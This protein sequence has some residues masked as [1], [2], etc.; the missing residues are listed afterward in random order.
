M[1]KL[2]ILIAFWC[3]SVNAQKNIPIIKNS[4]IQK[5]YQ[6]EELEVLNK[7]ILKN[8]YFERISSLSNIIPY[9]ALTAK[10]NI[11]YIDIGIPNTKENEKLFT[12]QKLLITEYLKETL[13]F[14]ENI[15]AYSSK[16]DLIKSILFYEDVLKNI[17]ILKED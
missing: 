16:D 5:Y 15:I 8:L 11:S 9:L 17:E 13:V 6:R 12:K 3:L 2:T 4:A 10:T 14:Q 7:G 1:K